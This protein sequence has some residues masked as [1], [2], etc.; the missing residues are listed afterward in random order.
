MTPRP[1]RPKPDENEPEVVA[2][3]KEAGFTVIRTSPLPGD[4]R[5]NP[6]DLFVGK[7]EA[8][9]PWIQV[10][11]KVDV[12]AQFTTNEIEYLKCVGVWPTPF[13]LTWRIPIISATSASEIV[14]AL[15]KLRLAQRR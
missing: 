12:F 10:E 11:I 1:K 9:W 13:N 2:E 14:D 8:G 3:L 5:Y 6:L 7:P 4:E 15:E